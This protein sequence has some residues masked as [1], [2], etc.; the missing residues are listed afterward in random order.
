M[1]E[2]VVYSGIHCAPCDAVK[3]YLKEKGVHYTEKNINT[4]KAAR[5]EL[6]DM[7]MTSIPVTVIGE[8]RIQGFE[9]DQLEAALAKVASYQ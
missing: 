9:K 1:Q 6:R 7:G 4:D 2:V 5:Q 3:A 8:E